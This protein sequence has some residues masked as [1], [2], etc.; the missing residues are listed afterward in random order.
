L[1]GSRTVFSDW[2]QRIQCALSTNFTIGMRVETV[3]RNNPDRVCPYRVRAIVG[4]RMWLYP[5][6]SDVPPDV[7][8]VER[9]LR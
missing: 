7:S 4:C 5:N 8:D 3:D 2:T 9:V 6:D 1:T